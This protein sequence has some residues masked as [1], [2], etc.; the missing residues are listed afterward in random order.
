MESTTVIT[1]NCAIAAGCARHDAIFRADSLRCR[2]RSAP[3]SRPVVLP[4]CCAPGRSLGEALPAPV[5]L[6]VKIG[7]T[8]PARGAA[9]V[10]RCRPVTDVLPVVL[11]ARQLPAGCPTLPAR[12][13]ADVPRSRPIAR[14][15]ARGAAGP[16]TPGRLPPRSRPVTRG[17]VAGPV[18]LPVK[19][20]PT[21]PA[22]WCCRRAALPV[23]SRPGCPHA[24]GR[25]LGEALPAPWCCRS[26]SAPRSRPVLPTCCAAGHSGSVAGP[27]GAAG[28]D[29]PHAP[30][31][32]PD[33]LPVVLPAGCPTLPA[34]HS[35]KRCR[36]VRW[37]RLC[38]AR[39]CRPGG[40]GR[41]CRLR[42]SCR[43]CR[44]PF[45]VSNRARKFAW[46][47]VRRIFAGRR[48]RRIR[49]FQRRLKA[50]P[51]IR[52]AAFPWR[53]GR[54]PS[55]GEPSRFSYA[56]FRAYKRATRR[57]ADAADFA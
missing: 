57:P 24:P 17:S 23:N 27:R 3:R 28:Q 39:M 20:G 44:R 4:T 7:P 45:R 1:R 33:V 5:V 42:R 51:A 11:P 12:R 21:L 40:A 18:V 43:L 19:I 14:R 22:P 31:R 46:K 30:G 15:A 9:D 37:Q 32:L 16:S 25:S 8:L 34:G 26:R 54:W 13:A 52:A 35:G 2:S 49:R 41:S 10:L 29:R 48:F 6:P 50:H 38:G 56:P 36:P 53:S 47:T 55:A